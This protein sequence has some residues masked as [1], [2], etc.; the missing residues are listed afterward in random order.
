ML[1]CFPNLAAKISAALDAHAFGRP[2]IQRD[3]DYEDL[4]P[5]SEGGLKRLADL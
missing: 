5:G 4:H 3:C 1:T 2:D